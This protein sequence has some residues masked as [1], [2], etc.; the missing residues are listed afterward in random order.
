MSV[1][2]VRAPLSLGG[3]GTD[4]DIYYTPFAGLVVSTAIGPYA[5]AEPKQRLASWRWRR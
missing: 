2:V 1:R 5:W 4:M 3:G